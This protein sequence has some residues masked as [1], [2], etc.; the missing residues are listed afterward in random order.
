MSR[1]IIT[2]EAIESIILNA[3]LSVDGVYD[4][5]R[6]IEEYIPYLNK[7]KKHP[8][9]ID[10]VVKNGVL[11]ANVFITVKYGFDLRKIGAEVRKNI[12]MQVES[13]TPFK[14]GE[15]NIVIEDV[16]YEH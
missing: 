2:D 4:T 16:K 14:M 6:G 1:V 13:M 7:D 9:G 5:W 8:H 3:T 12:K 11:S 15:L 10:F